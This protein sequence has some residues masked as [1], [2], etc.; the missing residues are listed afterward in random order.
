MLA[1]PYSFLFGIV[2]CWFYQSYARVISI[3][4]LNSSFVCGKAVRIMRGSDI[5]GLGL[6]G[7]EGS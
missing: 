4:I 1:G 5:K 3:T 7:S 2:R 6:G